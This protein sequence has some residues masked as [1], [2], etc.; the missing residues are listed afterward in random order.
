MKIENVDILLT[1]I[2]IR[3]GKNNNSYLAISF[4]DLTTGQNFDVIDKDIERIQKLQ[5]M[6]KYKVTLNLNSTKYGLQLTID[7]LLEKL[8]AI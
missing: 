6:T 7:K 2:E 3:T 1:R 4:V 8:G 5:A